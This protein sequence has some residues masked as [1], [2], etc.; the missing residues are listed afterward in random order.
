MNRRRRVRLINLY[1][2]WLS[3]ALRARAWHN[4]CVQAVTAKQRRSELL[5][6]RACKRTRV[7]VAASGLRIRCPIGFQTS[8]VVALLAHTSDFLPR[9]LHGDARLK[10]SVSQI[11]ARS[12]VRMRMFRVIDGSL[13][14]FACSK[15]FCP[16]QVS[17]VRGFRRDSRRCAPRRGTLRTIGTTSPV[18]GLPLFTI[19][20][21]SFFCSS[22]IGAVQQPTLMRR[23]WMPIASADS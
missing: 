7:L 1:V 13:S 20:G 3:R 12:A 23:R 9:V 4:S 18:F 22:N 21:P 17:P 19:C 2:I 11:R 6:N 8:V 15:C 5:S 10:P 14:N 16:A